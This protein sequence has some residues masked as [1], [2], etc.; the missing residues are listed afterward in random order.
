MPGH[1]ASRY[2]T[3]VTERVFCKV[4][5]LPGNDV[6]TYFDG[7]KARTGRAHARLKSIGV[8]GT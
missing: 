6:C 2:G 5:N 3:Q 8:P 4:L 7:L 1:N